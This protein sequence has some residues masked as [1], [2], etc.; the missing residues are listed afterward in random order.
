MDP[1]VSAVAAGESNPD[2]ACCFC[3]WRSSHHLRAGSW[4][5]CHG[6]QQLPSPVRLLRLRHLRLLRSAC[7]C[8]GSRVDYSLD[9]CHRAMTA[10]PESPAALDEP[11]PPLSPRWHRFWGAKLA[12]GTGTAR[13]R[14]AG[15][16]ARGGAPD[17]A[18][19]EAGIEGDQGSGNGGWRWPRPQQGRMGRR[20]CLRGRA[21]EAGGGRI[22]GN[23]KRDEEARATA[24]KHEV[25][26]S[27][28]IRG[29]AERGD[30]RGAIGRWAPRPDDEI[31]GTI[32]QA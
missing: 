5:P 8:F 25:M 1:L 24:D 23:G 6:P 7:S 31:R 27:R 14:E 22:L 29:R 26:T 15:S 21:V 10:S 11:P 3:S 17:L 18:E 19:T 13:R 12:F 4:A 28:L 30:D 32:G 2:D 16:G 20:R 9:C